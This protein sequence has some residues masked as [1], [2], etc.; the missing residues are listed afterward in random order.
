M[1]R[2]SFCETENS[3]S[4][5]TLKYS[6]TACHR[7]VRRLHDYL[8]RISCCHEETEKK[9]ISQNIV[10]ESAPEKSSKKSFVFSETVSSWK[11]NFRFPTIFSITLHHSHFQT[12]LLCF[13]CCICYYNALSCDFAFDDSLAVKEN[14]DLRPETPILSLLSN[15]FWGQPMSKVRT[16]KMI[17]TFLFLL[18]N[19]KRW[20]Q[21]RV[22][23]VGA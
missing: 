23:H 15:D 12:A 16:T 3:K 1:N 22:E 2:F 6:R 18:P 8:S 13:L 11:E 17:F 20:R 9:S 19:V 21:S 14:A 10:A 4:T 7:G 5:T